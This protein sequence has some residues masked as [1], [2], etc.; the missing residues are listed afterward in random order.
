[1]PAAVCAGGACV[2]TGAVPIHVPTDCRCRT[3]V[4]GCPA[5]LDQETVARLAHLYLC[6]G[7][8][9]YQIASVTGVDRQRVTRLLRKAGVR[10]RP[11]G[12]G[13][14][15]PEQRRGDPPGLPG[16]LAELYLRRNLTTPE[17]AAVL[18]IPER[19]IRDR[20]RRYNI[21]T[22]T[23]GRCNRE[24]RRTIPPDVLDDLYTKAG[25]SAREIADRLGSSIPVIL[26]NAHDQGIAVRA[27]GDQPGDGEIELIN[28][29]YAD[30]LVA[31]SLARHQIARVPPGNPIWLRFPEPVPLTRRLVEDLYWRC[32]VGLLHIE[33]LTG[34]PAD[35]IRG[36]MR[37]SGISTRPPGGRSPFLRRW[38]TGSEQ[39]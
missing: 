16:L 25:L 36:F 22:R 26:R 27:D 28:A 1:M 31:A 8:S 13:G 37:R 10:L 4:T 17:I 11:R 19:T 34:Q 9:T 15:R 6:A 33:L 3:L 38:R 18:G 29:L 24:D 20:L 2:A 23:R 39:P 35:T 21:P 7:L 12:A 5:G 32:G 30:R 14:R